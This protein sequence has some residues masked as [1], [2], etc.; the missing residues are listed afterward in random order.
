MS[1]E[2]YQQQLES[3]YNESKDLDVQTTAQQIN[4]YTEMFKIGQLSRDEYVQ[5][6][7]DL[8]RVAMLQRTMDNM[9]SMEYLN[10]AI[11]GLISLA[12]LA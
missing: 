7:A 5:T 2:Q 9:K 3:A 4:Q 1:I 12:S 10:A 6:L 8:Q 11:T